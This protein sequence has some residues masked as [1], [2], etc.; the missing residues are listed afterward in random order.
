M[1]DLFRVR[2]DEEAVN[3]AFAE[4]TR[5]DA[6]GRRYIGQGA[7]CAEFE[8]AFGAFIG[9]PEP[10]LLLNSAGE[11][12]PI[13]APHDTPCLGF[14]DAES[15]GEACTGFATVTALANLQNHRRCDFHHRM[16][17]ATRDGFRVRFGSVAFATRQAFWMRA[18]AV[19]FALGLPALRNLVLHIVQ[20]GTRKQVLGV[21]AR[22]IVTGVASKNLVR[23][24]AISQFISMAMGNHAAG[25]T[26]H[27][28]ITARIG[29]GVNGTNPRPA[30]IR[31]SRLVNLLPKEGDLLWG[32]MR[33]HRS[34]LTLWCHA[35]AVD[36]ARGLFV[37]P[38]IPLGGGK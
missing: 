21:A 33:V 6:N 34:L 17:L 35:P 26:L 12:R 22:S 25:A 23:Q 18:R 36:A 9:A 20:L 3:R 11:M 38:I 8:R 1:I 37:A 29:P 10:P 30:T 7:K 13:F 27:D 2:W 5:A 16:G 4:A 28:A 19:A 32:I 14:A 31:A 15:A 24:W